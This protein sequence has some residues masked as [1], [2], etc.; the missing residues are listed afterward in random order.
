MS[1]S[2]NQI[3][4]HVS[5]E[6]MKCQAPPSR[7]RR[8]EE[9]DQAAFPF[10]KEPLQDRKIV[11]AAEIKCSETHVAVLPEEMASYERQSQNKQISEDALAK[12]PDRSAVEEKES[13]WDPKQD[14]KIVSAEIKCSDVT[15]TLIRERL[16]EALSKVGG[17]V[18][19]MEKKEQVRACD[20]VEV[21]VAVESMLFK[22]MGPSRG[23]KAAVQYRAI[24]FNV[25]DPK[26]PDF[27]RKLL[28][29]EVKPETLVTMLSEEMASDERQRQT[30]Q[31]REAAF[32]KIPDHSATVDQKSAATL[33]CDDQ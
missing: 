2:R 14:Q 17:E 23:T 1:L 30:N 16:V 9:E 11:P 26:N 31:I 6:S 12:I 19:E 8:F 21:A 25:K 5:V 15:R 28:L 18:E 29:G 32:A 13:E 33:E 22:N 10:M 3:G 20:P 27:R 24:L 7:K 4:N